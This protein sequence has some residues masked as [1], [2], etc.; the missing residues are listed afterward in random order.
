MWRNSLHRSLM[1]ECDMQQ[2]GYAGTPSHVQVWWGPIIEME[3]GC[4]IHY[5]IGPFGVTVEW[6]DQPEV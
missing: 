4:L 1:D 6:V 2:S 5:F 3:P